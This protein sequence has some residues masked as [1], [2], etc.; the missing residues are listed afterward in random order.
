[1]KLAERWETVSDWLN[2]DIKVRRIDIGLCLLGALIV[3]Y[4]GY[5]SGLL[6]ALSG[7]LMY[8]LVIMVC[9]WLI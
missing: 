2:T 6:G 4:H 5:F 7:G 1:M 8:A 3:A 9:V